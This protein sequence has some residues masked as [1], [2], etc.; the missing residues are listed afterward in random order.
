MF[1]AHVEGLEIIQFPIPSFRGLASK[2]HQYLE[3][4]SGSFLKSL[5]EGENKGR[6]KAS[7]GGGS[8]YFLFSPLF[9]EDS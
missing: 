2:I 5:D 4:W 6:I 7:L 1:A 3:L 9:G 8:K